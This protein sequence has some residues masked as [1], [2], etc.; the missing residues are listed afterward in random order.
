M[1]R[2]IGADHVIDYTEEDFT[3][4]DVR[5]D[6][7]LDNV[8]SHTLRAMWGVLAPGGV[9]VPSSGHAGLSYVAKAAL[10]APFVR[11]Q[12]KAFVSHMS[13]EDLRDLSG[14]IDKGT[15]KPVVDRTYKLE[16]TRD[17]FAYLDEGHARGKVVIVVE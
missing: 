7:I 8:A 1:V 4:G 14:L 13:Q 12:G 11:K 9:L 6:A 2:E 15:V 17:A 5:Y 3:R 16:R 10:S